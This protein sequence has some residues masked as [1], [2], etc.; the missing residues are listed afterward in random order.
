MT[1]PSNAEAPLAQPGDDIM[2]DCVAGAC[3]QVSLP[4]WRH[5]FQFMLGSIFNL[6][7]NQY[8]K[9]FIL[10]GSKKSQIAIGV[11]QID[12]AQ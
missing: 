2:R 8:Q 7:K 5:H 4:R 11:C 10:K 1:D 3:Q 6:K 12:F 9:A